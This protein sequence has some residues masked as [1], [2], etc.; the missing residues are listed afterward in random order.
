MQ[1]T[2]PWITPPTTTNSKAKTNDEFKILSP[3]NE[4]QQRTKGLPDTYIS[5]HQSNLANATVSGCYIL[6][7]SRR[8]T[9]SCGEWIPSL[10]YIHYYSYYSTNFPV[11]IKLARRR[12][13]DGADRATAGMDRRR[14]DV[15]E[16]PTSK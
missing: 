16:T 9:A 10:I 7:L 1:E 13:L 14:D 2:I 8:A 11:V 4:K 3:N 12:P 6:H 5:G 15:V